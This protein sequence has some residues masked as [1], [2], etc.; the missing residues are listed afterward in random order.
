MT[1]AI[2]NEVFIGYLDMLNRKNLLDLDQLNLV[3]FGYNSYSVLFLLEGYVKL[4]CD[5]CFQRAFT[6]CSC[7]FKAIT[8]VGSNQGNYFENARWKRV[9]QRSF[10]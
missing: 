9:S 7:V 6:A 4:S 1:Y 3:E 2:C 8:L 5:T 10:K